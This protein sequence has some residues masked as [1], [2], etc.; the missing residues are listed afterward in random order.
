[1]DPGAPLCDSARMIKIGTL[2]YVVPSCLASP[3]T[4]QAVGRIVRGGIAAVRGAATGPTCRAR[5]TTW[6]SKAGPS[7]AA[8]TSCAPSR[9]PARMCTEMELTARPNARRKPEARRAHRRLRQRASVDL[10]NRLSIN[11]TAISAVRLRTSSAGLSS[12][13]SSEPSRPGVGDHLHA[14][15]HLAP[16]RPAA[17]AGAHAGRVVRIEAVEVEAHVQMGVVVDVLQRL[18]H[19]RAHAVLVDVPHVEHTEAERP[20]GRLLFRI[21]AADADEA[22]LVMLE[23]RR[24]RRSSPSAPPARGRAGRTPA[25]RACCRSGW[26]SRC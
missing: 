11:S 23:A 7:T 20:N 14:Q 24:A 10:P 1:M 2:C 5:T 16:G 9:I 18:G 4:Q 15:L 19:R 6:P 25:C 22:D 8:A 13:T 12:T 21:D 3:L 26:W 17:H